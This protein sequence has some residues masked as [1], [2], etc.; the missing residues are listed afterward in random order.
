MLSFRKKI[1][2]QFQENLWIDGQTKGQILL[3]PLPTPPWWSNKKD[4]KRSLRSN[5]A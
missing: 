5:I 3:D 1:M 4:H 2:S